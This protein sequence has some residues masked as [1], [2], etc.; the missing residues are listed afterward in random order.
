MVE[1]ESAALHLGLRVATIAL[2]LW[3]GSRDLQRHT[4]FADALSDRVAGNLE[5]RR[6]ARQFEE[7]ADTVA[8]HVLAETHDSPDKPQW[9]QIERALD[10]VGERFGD[11]RPESRRLWRPQEP[12]ALEPIIDNVLS[13]HATVARS[14]S[15]VA[16]LRLGCV[17]LLRILSLLPEGLEPYSGALTEPGSLAQ[18][19]DAA[20]AQAAQRAPWSTA[21]DALDRYRRY[22]AE[23]MD[24]LELVGVHG[25][26]ARTAPLAQ[27]YVVPSVRYLNGDRH[28]SL[29]G[30]LETSRCLIVQG[31]SGAGKSTMLRWIAAR[32][33]RG[34]P[35]APSVSSDPWLPLVVRMREWT[36]GPLDEAS[37][38]DAVMQPSTR[39]LSRAQI[40]QALEGGSGVLLLDGLDEV[41]EPRRSALTTWLRRL[42]ARLPRTR[43]IAS[44]RPSAVPEF[45]SADGFDI[46]DLLPMDR[47]TIARFVRLWFASAA[48]PGDDL[49]LREDAL[50]GALAYNPRVGRLAGNPLMCSLMCA[51]TTAHRAA[52]PRDQEIYQFIL[53]TLLNREAAEASADRPRLGYSEKLILLEQIAYWFLLN[54][55]VEADRV[56]VS[57]R[58]AHELRNMARIPESPERVLDA[59]IEDGGVLRESVVGRID[60]IHQIF[61]DYLAARA[62]VDHGTTDVLI[63]YAHEDRWREVIALAAGRVPKFECERLIDGVLGRADLEARARRPLLATARLCLEDR[64]DVTASTAQLW[65][66]RIAALEQADAT[67]PEALYTPT[68]ARRTALM[69]EIDSYGSPSRTSTHQSSMRNMLFEALRRAF[70]ESDFPWESCTVQDSGDTALI[71]A[72]SGVSAKQMLDSPL[73]DRIVSH[74]GRHN[75]RRSAEALTRLRVSVVEGVVRA[76]GHGLAGAVINAAARLVDAHATRDALRESHALAAVILSDRVY[77]TLGDT[78]RLYSRRHVSAKEFSEDA[79][80]RLIGDV[81]TSTTRA[82]TPE[83]PSSPELKKAVSNARAAIELRSFHKPLAEVET[84]ARQAAAPEDLL[85]PLRTA[86]VHVIAQVRHSPE[87]HDLPRAQ[88]VRFER[89]G[90]CAVSVPAAGRNPEDA[91]AELRRIRASVQLPLL[92]DDL[93]VAHYQVYEARAHGADAVCLLAAALTQNELSALLRTT[94]DLGMSAI[95]RVATT[96]EVDRALEAGAQAFAIAARPHR[97]ASGPSGFAFLA[98]QLPASAVKI[99]EA[100]TEQDTARGLWS[101][102]D[103]G[104]DAILIG[105][106]AFPSEDPETFILRLRSTADRWSR[107]SEH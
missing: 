63:R 10:E 94:E 106:D 35:P 41:P 25:A 73:L 5:R 78:R 60:F 22:V 21:D 86:G 93:L 97:D 28:A 36:K 51:V 48:S 14:A 82:S 45:S 70:D 49:S 90:A 74:V 89:G 77:C 92:Y 20:I 71:L 83:L 52:F 68:G 64:M 99:A 61:Q 11:T 39:I 6:L 18:A 1:M 44:S 67:R 54:R 101:Y 65:L 103:M 26:P 15:D 38:A 2:R 53:E 88:A 32:I 85:R 79:W 19:V 76:D 91:L 30:A 17:A 4:D 107:R 62:V 9:S 84:Q 37:L 59:L 96:Y 24:R 95:V 40:Q 75:A 56:A 13:H 57:A 8:E 46:V 34:E 69:V 7:V 31:E 87:A 81:Q 29:I 12:A 16:V 23:S 27:M 102:A 47:A 55:Y 33:A 72:P 43:I 3:L 98:A 104:A 100:R 66:Q 58:I 80:I 50:L 105:A 42:P